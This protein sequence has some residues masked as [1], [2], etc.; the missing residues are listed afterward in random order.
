MKLSSILGGVLG[1]V[2]LGSFAGCVVPP[3]PAGGVT[4]QYVLVIDDGAGGLVAAPD[5]ASAGVAKIKFNI[6]DD[7]NGNGVLDAAEAVTQ[8][9]QG[10]NQLDGDNDGFIDAT[11][12]GSFDSGFNIFPD[13][14]QAFS[15]EFLDAAN[16]NIPWTTDP[17]GATADVFTFIGANGTTIIDGSILILPFVGDGNQLADELQVFIF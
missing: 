12:L 14:Y 16:Q 3:E 15:I 8:I 9:E 7:E 13:T 10:C 6:G 17:N 4:L 2:V 11:E 5:C 1:S